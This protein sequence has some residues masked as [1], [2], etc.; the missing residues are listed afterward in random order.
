MQTFL[1]FSDFQ[2]SAEILDWRRLGKQRLESN[3]IL[4][5]IEKGGKWENHPAVLMWVGYEE[6]LKLYRN[7]M[8]KEWVRRGYKNTMEILHVGEL[9][10]PDW[11]GNKYLHLSHKSKLYHEK[12]PEYYNFWKDVPRM[13]YM[14]PVSKDNRIYE[15]N[16]FYILGKDRDRLK[17]NEIN[18]NYD[19]LKKLTT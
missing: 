12:D 16:L 19:K 7:I 9:V 4:N 15:N 3:Q 17:L 5:I 8:I 11:L 1:P 13:P 14:W 10:Y 18:F 2:K 6:L